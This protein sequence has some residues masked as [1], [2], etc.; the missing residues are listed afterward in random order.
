M[1]YNPG[2]LFWRKSFPGPYGTYYHLFCR[3]QPEFK[4]RLLLRSHIVCRS[5]TSWHCPRKYDLYQVR[6]P[7]WALFIWSAEVF[8]VCK[9]INVQFKI[10]HFIRCISQHFNQLG[11]NPM[12]FV[13]WNW[14]QILCNFNPGPCNSLSDIPTLSFSL[15]LG[16]YDAWLRGP[17]CWQTSSHGPPS[18]SAGW[19]S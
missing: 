4:G 13:V 19:L 3:I 15:V 17:S 16:A 7:S 6:S 1:N 9:A 12:V 11:W 18:S 2:K 8:V 14:E 10:V 5:R